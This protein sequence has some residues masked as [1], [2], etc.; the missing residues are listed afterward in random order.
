MW[1]AGGVEGHFP[2]SC[3]PQPPLPPLRV[4][5]HCSPLPSAGNLDDDM[6]S[7]DPA[8]MTWTLLS[9]ANDTRRPSARCGHGFTSAGDLL[10][11]HGGT[12]EG[13]ADP[14]GMELLVGLRRR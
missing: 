8:T 9:A 2:I 11:V 3:P 1:W 4:A 14:V 7:F 13:A 10:Y 12:S 6:H 5:R